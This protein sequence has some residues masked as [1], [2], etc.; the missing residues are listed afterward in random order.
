MSGRA[1]A[2]LACLVPLV[3]CEQASEPSGPAGSVSLQVASAG[4]ARALDAGRVHIEGPTPRVV[5][6]TPGSTVTVDQLQPG[7]YTVSL[8]GFVGGEVERFG[9]ATNVQVV[10]GQ[11]RSVTVTFNVFRPVLN[12]VTL[13]PDGLSYI[14]SFP[15]LAAADSYRVQTAE[16]EDFSNPV[17]QVLSGTTATLPIDGAFGPRFIRVQAFDPYR[18]TGAPSDTKEVAFHRLLSVAAADGY[19]LLSGGAEPIDD[20]A[21]LGDDGN[22]VARSFFSFD[23]TPLAPGAVAT[24]A[25]L[26]LFQGQLEGEPYVSLGNVTVDHMDYGATLDG[27]DYDLAPL[28][29][30]IGV[31]STTA[32]LESKALPVLA[33]VTADLIAARLTSQFRLRFS[34]Q[35]NDGDL[36]FDFVSFPT[37]ESV[38]NF[39]E[40]IVVTE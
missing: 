38:E 9:R 28:T 40:L 24:G 11:N 39:P 1:W 12:P 17:A 27:T 16:S 21:F 30:N 20:V 15:P 10:A 13:S 34:L 2:A 8:Q 23:L 7:S 31:L 33:A 35:D 26:R 5:D 4:A 22:A 3:A 37:A 32:A 25:V 36:A 29:A 19:A 14:V 6:V 18:S